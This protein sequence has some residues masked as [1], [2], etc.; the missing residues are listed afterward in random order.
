MALPISSNTTP[1]FTFP[2][3]PPELRMKIWRLS[4]PREQRVVISEIY[5]YCGTPIIKDGTQQSLYGYVTKPTDS[6]PGILQASRE[7]RAE[8]LKTYTLTWGVHREHPIYVNYSNDIFL[9]D[10][11]RGGRK[12][13]YSSHSL[14]CPN[15]LQ[16]LDFFHRKLRHLIISDEGDILVQSLCDFKEF[17]NLKLLIIPPLSFGRDP[18]I[19]NA[20]RTKLQEYWKA[21]SNIGFKPDWKLSEDGCRIR[22]ECSQARDMIW[23]E[24]IRNRVAGGEII[25]P[26]EDMAT[27]VLF[28]ETEEI[29]TWFQRELGYI[30]P[31]GLSYRQ[32]NALSYFFRLWRED[33]N[34]IHERNGNGQ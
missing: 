1:T 5:T 25:A 15:A 34:A 8:S 3:L 33:L 9:F 31:M 10:P 12:N 24:E 18:S 32:K 17:V 27:E 21:A 19:E 13:V 2:R 23:W 6:V 26:P 11:N 28:L 30:V 16:E 20:G 22:R 7:S 14:N 29:Q 4:I